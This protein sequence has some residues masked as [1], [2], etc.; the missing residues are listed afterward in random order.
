MS[1]PSL[2]STRAGRVSGLGLFVYGTLMDADVRTLVIGRP[3]EAAQ[4]QPAT[5]KNMRRVYIAGRVYPMVVPRRGDAVQGLLLTGLS[6]ED[7]ARLDAF[8]GGDYRRERQPIWP[9]DKAEPVNAWLYRTRGVGPQPSPRPWTLET[10]QAREKTQF[11]REAR[12]WLTTAT[13]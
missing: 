4:A 11:L 8:E 13:R 9:D 3:L 5:L 6:E 2:N 12:I 10:W 1:D 7:F